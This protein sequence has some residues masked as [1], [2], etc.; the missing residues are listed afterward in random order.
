M[1]ATPGSGLI[2]R[3][4]RSRKP[5]RAARRPRLESGTLYQD[6]GGTITTVDNG[7]HSFRLDGAANVYELVSNGN[8][9]NG[10]CWQHEDGW[11]Y[12]YLRRE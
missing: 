11:R 7:V 12:H 3:S 2:A 5:G 10:L 4:R 1:G 8:L 9:H 6:V